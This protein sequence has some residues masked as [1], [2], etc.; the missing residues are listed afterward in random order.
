M[1]AGSVR[2]Q[3]AWS[4]RGYLYTSTDWRGRFLLYSDCRFSLLYLVTSGSFWTKYGHY[5]EEDSQSPILPRGSLLNKDCMVPC[6]ADAGCAVIAIIEEEE[7]CLILPQPLGVSTANDFLATPG[8][9]LLHRCIRDCSDAYLAGF[10]QSGLVG[11]CPLCHKGGQYTDYCFI[12]RC[13]Q[14]TEGGGWTVSILYSHVDTSYIVLFSAQVFFSYSYH[15]F[16]THSYY[17]PGFP[18]SRRW[19]RKLCSELEF[20][21]KRLW[22]CLGRLLARSGTSARH[23][24]GRKL[25]AVGCCQRR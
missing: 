3:A 11:I 9:V 2:A 17:I 10:T 4:C 22:I 15:Q 21:Q 7:S 1:L 12:V 8:H 24:D 20:L 13:D 5:I 19:F 6:A 16:Y 14:N 25:W 18:I 23:R